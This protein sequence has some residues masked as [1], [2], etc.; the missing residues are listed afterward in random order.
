MPP[1]DEFDGDPYRDER[2]ADGLAPISA[3]QKLVATLIIIAALAMLVWS[4]RAHGQEKLTPL[5]ETTVSAYTG[6]ASL[7]T[8]GEKREY[9]HGRAVITTPFAGRWAA[10]FRGDLS[11]TQDAGA[12]DLSTDPRSFRIIEAAAGVRVRLGDSDFA[13]GC[14]GGFTFS[15]EGEQDAPVDPNLWS[16]LCGVRYPILKEGYVYVTSG[17]HEPVGYT[18][19]LVVSVVVPL[20]D[21]ASAFSDYALPFSRTAFNDRAWTWRIGTAVRVFQHKVN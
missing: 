17:L 18:G 13:F 7:L 10:F 20:R 3:G 19:A 15:I 5:G 21:R 4:I 14:L 12:L 8:G 6:V 2:D 1:D 11:A 16:A 9:V